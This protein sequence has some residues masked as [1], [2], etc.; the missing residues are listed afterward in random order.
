MKFWKV[1]IPTPQC[2]SPWLWHLM[3]FEVTP[4]GSR[5]TQG[6]FRRR[7]CRCMPQPRISIAC[8][9]LAWFYV[10]LLRSTRETK[11]IPSGSPVT[12]PS[13]LKP[14]DRNLLKSQYQSNSRR[15]GSGTSF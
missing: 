4:G 7:I 9:G 14:H 5:V 1:V 6:L 2:L 8:G 11:C 15:N 12:N 10:A 13:P 3:M